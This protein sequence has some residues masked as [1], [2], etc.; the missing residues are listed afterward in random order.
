VIA[1]FEAAVPGDSIGIRE[2]YG[3]NSTFQ[4]TKLSRFTGPREQWYS[5]ATHQ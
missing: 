4:T 3:S 2:Q 1:R 5:L